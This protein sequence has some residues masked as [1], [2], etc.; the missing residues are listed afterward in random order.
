MELNTDTITEIFRVNFDFPIEDTILGRAVRMDALNAF[1]FAN[2]TG[3]GYL[4][5][6]SYLF[7]PKGCLN[8][9]R[10]AFQ[11]H[12]V[13]GIFDRQYLMYS[14]TELSRV[15]PYLFE[16]DKY[17]VLK[18]GLT[19]SAFL[20]EQKEAVKMLQTHGYKTTDFLFLRIEAWKKGNGMESFLEYLACEYFK[21]RGYIVQNQLPLVH[22]VGTPDFG[23]F[24]LPDGAKGFYIA[25][26]AMLKITGN[27][28]ILDHLNLS[29]AIV[30]EAKTSTTAMARQL[31]K[32]LNTTAFCKGY[33]MH[34]DK[35]L[36]TRDCFGM[37]HI[38]NDYIVQCIEPA[39][40]YTESGN[41]VFDYKEYMEW[42][43]NLLKFYIAANF[44]NEE[45]K[46]F[47]E[48][49]NAK[50]KYNQAKMI[51]VIKNTEMDEIA[52]AVRK[53]VG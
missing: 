24:R 49:R 29:H 22:A 8:I 17:I 37:F 53:A 13:T 41:I 46:E 31:E 35:P 43:Q 42:Y 25:E 50:G 47:V 19:E 7:T 10:E 14:P 39:S 15:K 34:P 51:D 52:E 11:Y 40:E 9:L 32:Y 21:K 3:A 28:D 16:G 12:F 18:E 38:R 23:G 45:L 27:T 4:D 20:K 1:L 26:L 2:V 5:D 48:K 36:P 6:P 33:E 30:G 44:S